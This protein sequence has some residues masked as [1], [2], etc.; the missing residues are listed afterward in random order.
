MQ[1][2]EEGLY[3]L[4]EP[5]I[6]SQGV[7]LVE[8]HW[9]NAGGREC[10]RIV[11]HAEAG[12]SHGDCSRVTRAVERAVDD[13]ELVPGS[14]VVEVTSPGLDRVLKDGREFE[15]FRGRRVRVWMEGDPPEREGVSLGL[16]GGEVQ[17]RLDDGELL[18]VPWPGIK[19]A[20]LVPEARGV[21]GNG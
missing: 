10:L 1:S 6:A 20:R 8:A 4:L 5:H 21:G 14:Y 15:I 3:D 16:A 13:E 9:T 12:V 19:K 18:T 2:Q 11:I 17:L 7:D